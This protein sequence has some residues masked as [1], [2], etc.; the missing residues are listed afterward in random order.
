MRI[1][2]VFDFFFNLDLLEEE[3][4]SLLFST[5]SLSSPRQKHNERHSITPYVL[6]QHTA[7]KKRNTQERR[8]RKRYASTRCHSKK[9]TLAPG[10]SASSLALKNTLAPGFTTS[11][12]DVHW[13]F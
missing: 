13:R 4:V 9:N 2:F 7:C 1:N 10:F 11:S 5:L 6:S 3:K 12:L 8:R